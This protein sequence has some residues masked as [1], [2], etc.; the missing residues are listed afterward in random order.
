MSVKSLNKGKR[1]ER[2][3]AGQLSEATGLDLRRTPLSGGWS[4][5]APG[6]VVGADFPYCVECKHSEDVNLES[7]LF[8][9]VGWLERYWN[10]LIGECPEGKVPV[11]V[12]K[13]RARV[14]AAGKVIDFVFPS[15]GVVYVDMGQIVVG[16]APFDWILVQLHRKYFPPEEL[17]LTAA[18]WPQV[19]QSSELRDKLLEEE[20]NKKDVESP[21]THNQGDTRP[22]AAQREGGIAGPGA[23]G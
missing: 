10:Q 13:K 9:Q 5:Q 6:D 19:F 23:D 11:L 3:V 18:D 1:F 12:F 8:G 16:I 14:L 20:R 22:G 21:V 15:R 4:S 2:W 17:P 7:L